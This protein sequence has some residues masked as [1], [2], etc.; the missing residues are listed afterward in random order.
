[1]E[2]AKKSKK[3]VFALCVLFCVTAC[4]LPACKASADDEKIRIGIVGFQSKAPGVSDHQA[5]IITD[6]FTRELASSQSISVYEREQLAKIGEEI[7]LSMSGLV[8]MDT[9]V[10]VGKIAGVQY[11]LTGAVTELSGSASGGGTYVPIRG[12]PVIGG[13]AVGG[14]SKKATAGIDIRIIDTS[15]AEVVL[16]LSE[17]GTA[18]NSTTA[19]GIAGFAAAETE[20]GGLEARAIADAVTRLSSGVR[21]AL[22]D[23]SHVIAVSGSTFTIDIG[24]TM[25]AKKGALY[26]VYADGPAVKGMKGEV[27]GREKIPLAVLKVDNVSAKHSTC[28]LAPGCKGDLIQRGDK[29]EPISAANAKNMKFA[30]TRPPKPRSD[31]SELLGE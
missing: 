21:E 14:G 2:L 5:G 31:L 18:T 26:L 11:I 25:G 22:G 7:K 3:W 23:S 13:V 4:L 24:S 30:S 19:I 15:T 17:K 10:E 12:A 27:L 1:M 16:A 29:I 8:D 20:F 28:T 6:L 9:A